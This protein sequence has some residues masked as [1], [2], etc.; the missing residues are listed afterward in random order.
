M[1]NNEIITNYNETDDETIELIQTDESYGEKREIYQC[2]I[3][4]EEE[5]D[6]DKLISPCRCSGTSKYVHIE[7]LK[8]WRY[9]DVDAPGFYRC[10]ECNEN[11]I[12]L[13]DNQLESDKI[14]SFLNSPSKI[15]YFELLLSFMLGIFIYSYDVYL[16]D[17]SLVKIFPRWHNDTFLTIVKEDYFYQNLFYT[18]VSL[19]IQNLSFMLIYILRCCLHVKNKKQL[20][21]LMKNILMICFAYY[22]TIWL[23]MLGM[24]FYNLYTFSIVTVFFYQLMGYKVNYQIIKNHNECILLIND[25]LD[26]NVASMDNN[27]LNV[28]VDEMAENDEILEDDE[29]SEKKQHDEND[30]VELLY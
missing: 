6:L 4:L 22:N 1:D 3:C 29:I 24:N 7:C 30:Y 25:N 5:E 23:F 19:Y 26:T 11:Y 2:R 15:F 18:D 12:I 17:F 16:N 13:N 28:V 8:Q 21:Y 14:F 20:S 27:P 9:Q 10:M